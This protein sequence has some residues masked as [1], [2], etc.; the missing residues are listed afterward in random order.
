[1]AL[2][3][4]KNQLQKALLEA[5]ANKIIEFRKTQTHFEKAEILYN[6]LTHLRLVRDSML[7]FNKHQQHNVATSSLPCA[8]KLDIKVLGEEVKECIE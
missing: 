2:E 3:V 6:N 4:V 1:M 5:D 7:L 8:E